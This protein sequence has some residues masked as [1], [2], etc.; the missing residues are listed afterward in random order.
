MVENIVI[1]TLLSHKSVRKFSGKMI[2]EEYVDIIIKAA[3]QASTSSNMQMYSI[4][5]VKNNEKK[6]LLSELCGNQ[7][8]IDTCPVFFVFCTDLSRIN[9]VCE[10]AGY[11]F[12]DDYLEIFLAGSMDTAIA[13]QNALAA[14]ESLGLGGVMI[15]GIRNN[16]DKVI[17]L[18]HL[19][20]YVYATVGLCLGY[21]AHNP[22]IKPR[23]SPEA[24]VHR[25]VYSTENTDNYLFEYDRIMKETSI[26]RGRKYPVKDCVPDSE[27]TVPE[28]KYGWIE[29]TARRAA[30]KNPVVTRK[31][32]KKI[33]KQQGFGLK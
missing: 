8:W 18:L 22:I 4:I 11:E 26:Y 33:I 1:K 24:V 14:A 5:V 13:C 20:K 17:G 30:S 23:L 32:L 27:D 12:I 9:R 21:P 2:P 10:I 3:Q 15:G 7:P 16:P 29:H 6:K 28:E 31:A 25:E 19:P